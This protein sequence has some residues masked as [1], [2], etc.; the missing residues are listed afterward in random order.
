VLLFSFGVHESVHAWATMRLGDPTAFMLGRITLNPA[1]N[2][3]PW[4]SIV[5]P[6][7]GFLLGGVLVGWG[8]PI[9]VTL[10]NFKKVKRDD[11]LSTAAGLFSHLVLAAIALVVLVAL[12]HSHGVGASAVVSAMLLAN[13]V[14]VDTTALPKL[15]P[16]ALLLYDCVIVNVLLFVFNLIPVP[17]LDGSRFIRYILSYEAEKMYDRLG[18]IGSFVV[19]FLAAQVVFPFFYTPM[20]G[21]FNRLLLSL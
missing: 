11:V 14:Q 5:M 8:K 15:F 1:R 9:P 16:V 6:L 21:I 19:F 17:P 10:R 7:V 20:I 3:D 2:I 18:M 13:K 4:G 12:K